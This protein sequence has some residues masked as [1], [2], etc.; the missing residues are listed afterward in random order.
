MEEQI[1]QKSAEMFLSM[2]FKTVTMD[3]IANELGISKKTLYQYFSNKNDLVHS[4]AMYLFDFIE[5][6]VDQICAKS[7][8]PIEEL[9]EIKNYVLQ[10]LKD[11]SSSPI[12][13]LQKYFPKTYQELSAKQFKKMQS[14]MVTNL[15]KGIQMGLFREDIDLEFVTRVYY[16]AAM[17]IR[18]QEVFPLDKFTLP[19]LEKYLLDYHLRAIVTPKG[20]EIIH[21]LN[22]QN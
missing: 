21:Q 9:Y 16:K 11:E 1:V 20:L 22:Q 10:N 17:V 3:D 12:Y 6:G 15:Q 2:G 13:Q 4:C 5:C 18:D 19:Q 8:N 14:C 7:Q